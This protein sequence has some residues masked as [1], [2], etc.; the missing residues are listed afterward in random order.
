MEN[1]KD[2]W[3]SSPRNDR[4]WSTNGIWKSW[5]GWL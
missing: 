1:E 2:R 5:S 4:G 3:L